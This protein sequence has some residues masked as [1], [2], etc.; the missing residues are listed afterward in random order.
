[1][2]FVSAMI[3]LRTG[4][5]V[6]AS[7]FERELAAGWPELPKPVW[8]PASAGQWS[9]SVGDG[10]VVIAAMGAPIPWSDL[11]PLC[12]AGRLWVDAESNLREH[13]DHLVV[14]VRTAGGPIEQ[15]KFLTQIC[16]AVLLGCEQALG[17]FWLSG[18][19][20]ISS[21]IFREFAVTVMPE[22][23]PLPI[24]IDV[25]AGPDAEGKTCGC[26]RGLAAF[27]HREIE[28]VDAQE[29]W[30]RLQ[31][32]LYDLAGY[33]LEHGP[34]IADGDTVGDHAS[35]RIR[36]VYGASELGGEGEVIH[37]QY[38]RPGRRKWQLWGKR[39]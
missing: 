36:V 7:R 13:R 20:L 24:W 18:S 35:E 22:T 21:S 23:L 31:E 10:D 32:R 25:Q 14:A 5:M 12:R 6:E 3:P 28:A 2:G 26:T 33:V 4:A 37:L 15:A 11:A 38:D 27:G 34:V 16:T 39:R 17:V 19:L 8:T 30:E 9:C 1:M 29:S